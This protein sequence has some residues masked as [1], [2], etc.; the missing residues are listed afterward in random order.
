MQY[1]SI[2]QVSVAA[3]ASSHH[4]I[5]LLQ[6]HVLIII[7]VEQVDGEELVRHAAWRLYAF[8]QLQ[9]VDD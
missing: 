8:D 2:S 3:A 7:K 5:I 4:V 9:G 1:L 6:H